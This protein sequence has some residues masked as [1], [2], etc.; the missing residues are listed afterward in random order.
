MHAPPSARAIWR[1]RDGVSIAVTAARGAKLSEDIAVPVDR[2]AEAVAETVRIGA[3]HDL[4]A[5][6]WG[7]AGDGNVHATF[8]LD[9]GD[10]AQRT[11]AG[12]AARELFDLALRL[13]G[14]V[15]AEH[16]IGLLKA[17][18]LSRQWPPAAVAAHNADQGGARP[19]GSLQPGKEAALSSRPDHPNGRRGRPLPANAHPAASADAPTG[20]SDPFWRTCVS[21]K[22]LPDG[23]WKPESMP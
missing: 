21:R 14:T 22:L 23:S 12:E 19:E 17:G 9:P 13:G 4:E 3:R 10:A 1:W 5:C 15:T 8:L 6:S 7:H 2:L 16:G 20:S 11:R 18:Q